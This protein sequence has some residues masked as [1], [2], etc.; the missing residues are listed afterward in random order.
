MAARFGKLSANSTSRNPC[1]SDMLSDART[2]AGSKITWVPMKHRHWQPERFQRWSNMLSENAA[3][4]GSRARE[5]CTVFPGS[6][7]R[8]AFAIGMGPL[9]GMVWFYPAF[10]IPVITG[11]RRHFSGRF[12]SAKWSGAIFEEQRVTTCSSRSRGSHQLNS[13]KL[14]VKVKWD[15]TSGPAP[16]PWYL[17]SMPGYRS[18]AHKWSN[19]GRECECFREPWTDRE[20]R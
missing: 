8:P 4:Q 11:S 13:G 14:S 6:P 1:W 17:T 10:V 15:S 5:A 2:R 12:S 20:E 16:L 19:R 9:P 7:M 3:V 18:S